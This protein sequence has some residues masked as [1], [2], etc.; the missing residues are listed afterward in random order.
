[1]DTL[2]EVRDLSVDFVTPRGRVHALRDVDLA[3]PRGEVVGH[4][5]RERH[6]AR[7]RWSAAVMRLLADNAEIR[8][9]E[10]AVRRPRHAAL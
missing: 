7:P 1:M 2:L 5:R 8:G 9:G 10:I 6:A 3:V 4:R